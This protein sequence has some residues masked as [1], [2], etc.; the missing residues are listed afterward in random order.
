MRPA[1]TLHP[2]RTIRRR[3]AIVPVPAI[4]DP[5]VDGAAHVIQPEGVRLE[6]ADPGW[7][8]ER[9]DIG[10]ALAIGHA[11]QQLVAPPVPCLRPAAGGIFPFGLGRQTIWLVRCSREPADEL[12]GVAPADIGD[13][14]VILAR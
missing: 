9:G 13:G 4:L 6:A 7:L 10:A 8:L 11:R 1:V 2:C 3:A 5:L 12:F 14:R